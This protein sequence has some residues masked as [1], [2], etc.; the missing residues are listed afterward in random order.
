[1]KKKAKTVE[2]L[3]SLYTGSSTPKFDAQKRLKLL[4]FEN[5]RTSPSNLGRRSST[6]KFDARKMLE[7]AG[8]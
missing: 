8:V 6:P 3:P 2:L 7:V 5:G 1:M 4:R